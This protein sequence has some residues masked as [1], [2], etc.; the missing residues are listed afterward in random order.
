M[1]LV[2]L[3]GEKLKLLFYL[4]LLF[5]SP[6][7]WAA[8]G[9]EEAI[10]NI[11][12]LGIALVLAFAA[13]KSAKFFKIPTV[14][15]Y[16][17]IGILLGPSAFNLMTESV[18]NG[19]D[20]IKQVA[21]GL[22]MFN[23]GGEFHRGLFK[24]VTRMHV[25]FS[26]LHAFLVFWLVGLITF[27]LSFATNLSLIQQ[28]IMASFLGLIAIEAAPP[29]STLV[30]K[31][32]DAKGPLTQSI[33]VYL[34]VST[35]LVIIGSQVLMFAYQ[36]LGFWQGGKGNIF[37]RIGLLIWSV[38]GSL[39]IGT[40]FGLLLSFWEQRENEE[41]EVLFA[42]ICS[43]LIGNTLAFY[44]GL[45]PL[46]IS[47]FTGFALVNTSP[48][49]QAIHAK[50]KGVGSSIYAIFFVLAGAH[51]HIQEQIQTVGILGLGYITARSFAMIF[52]SK[53]AAKY[54]GE[55]SIIGKHMGWSV[56]CHAGTAIA[57]VDKIS[58][59]TDASAQTVSTVILSS[60]FVFEII[61][62]LLLKHNL[63]Q[64]GEVKMGALLG[65]ISSGSFLSP[66]D[67]LQNSLENLGIIKPAAS[68]QMKGINLL[69]DRNVYAI[70]E[71][72]NLKEVIS[73]VD[74]RQLPIYPVVDE[75]YI[76]KGIIS[77]AELKNVMFDPFQ[78]RFTKASKLIGNNACLAENSTIDQAIQAFNDNELDV[79][80][81]VAQDSQK[82]I[83]M[84][85]Y[86]QV[87]LAMKK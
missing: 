69:I 2:S 10:D 66:S 71:S 56:L 18:S 15:A 13:G 83:G 49:G 59:Q 55:S 20:A 75:D 38:V 85:S 11:P 8:S 23:I 50:V 77:I 21:F 54:T 68:P 22:I 14:S 58:G 27:G 60:I 3:F 7:I 80:P 12:I 72:S 79:L 44:L 74:K 1:G 31:E 16:I 19:L 53:Y 26:L 33:M 9:V 64:L 17:F 29:T 36:D 39:F 25:R 41:S 35:F 63:I 52:S 40:L 81:V 4:I 47:I 37:L 32:M 48:A 46:L 65:G 61:G 30:M 73:F 86:K 34:A 70:E 42:V 5:F 28:I 51:I 82:L 43:L 62:P 87:L 84:L 76:Y 6:S 24:Q 57:V 67:L 78:A 45:E